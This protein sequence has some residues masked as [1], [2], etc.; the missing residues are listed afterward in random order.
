[1]LKMSLFGRGE[2]VYVCVYSETG[3]CSVSAGLVLT[4][5][6][7]DLKL[8]LILLPLPPKCLDNRCEP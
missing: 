2:F 1:M 7:A 5:T 8:L 4:V 6:Q 3:F